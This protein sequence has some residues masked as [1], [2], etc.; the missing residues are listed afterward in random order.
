MTEIVKAL[1]DADAPVTWS[2]VMTVCEPRALVQTNVLWHLATGASAVHVFFDDPGD[3]AMAS[4]R[5]IAGCQAVVCD[6]AHWRE[7]NGR[8]GRPAS[9]MRR[10][11]LNAN[12]AQAVARTD[13]LFHIDAD[14][15]IWQ[16]GNLRS[17]LE[18]LGR[19]QTE[20]NLPVLERMFV[21]TAGQRSVFDGMFRASSQL[22]GAD[23]RAAFGEFAPF[24]KRGQYSHGAGKSGIAVGQ[25][26]R[27][28]VHNATIRGSER[29]KRAPKQVS[30]T[31]RLLHF[32][33]LT[34]LHWAMKG[35]RYRLNPPDVR[36]AVLQTHRAAQIDWM[37]EQGETLEDLL[38]A[39]ASLFLLTSDRCRRLR[40]FD[41]LCEV[42]FD[43]GH[44]LGASAPDLSVAA[45]D[46]DVRARNPWLDDI[47]N[48]SD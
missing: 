44:V 35:M 6:S 16:D 22:S 36:N 27:L 8:K 17:E 40:G 30:R 37:L 39:H 10:Q 25:G 41:L 18:A 1:T 7:L 3:P 46:A 11:T 4:I 45:F 12:A 28:G 34:P 5:Q 15:F 24:M 42:P 14:E 43:P 31:T 32:D 29:W 19:G 23:A 47:L 26:L 9:Q 21:E 2:V 33:G 38:R 48:G 20:L 13:W